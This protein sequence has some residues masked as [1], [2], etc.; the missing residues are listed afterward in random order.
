MIMCQVINVSWWYS[1][2][3]LA[4]KVIK[5]SKAKNQKAKSK[6]HT[7][8]KQSSVENF[9]INPFN[10]KKGFPKLEEDRRM[11]QAKPNTFKSKLDS[12][13]YIN[14]STIDLLILLKLFWV[15]VSKLTEKIWC[16][17]LLQFSPKTQKHRIRQSGANGIDN[18][19]ILARASKAT[20]PGDQK[21]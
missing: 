2:W 10:S 18:R 11:S 3:S 9:A 1:Y 19:Q 20:D 21:L 12:L 16:A 17:N 14:N 13:K 7:S 5:L 15:L 4:G 8:S 6:R